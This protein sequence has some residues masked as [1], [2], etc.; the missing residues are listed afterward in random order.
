MD[1]RPTTIK[2]GLQQLDSTLSLMDRNVN[3]LGMEGSRMDWNDLIEWQRVL[4]FRGAG[5]L[6]GR[7]TRFDRLL[8][9]FPGFDITRTANGFA[10]SQGSLRWDI[11]DDTAL[12]PAEL[13]RCKAWFT[14]R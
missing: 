2:T 14:H 5:H 13:A 11:K 3:I 7:G 12:D 1:E 9:E 4:G 6:A 8:L 10:L